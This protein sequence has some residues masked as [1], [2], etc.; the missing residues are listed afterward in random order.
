MSG[1]AQTAGGTAQRWLLTL[2]GGLGAALIAYGA[3][4]SHGNPHG[5]TP[6]P[7]LA[8]RLIPLELLVGLLVGWLVWRAFGRRLGTAPRTD[9]QE[10]MVYR[11]AMRRGGRFTL[12]ELEDGSPLAPAQAREVLERLQ[13]SGRLHRDGDTYHLNT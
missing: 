2:V 1:P 13:D 5:G 9:A 6:D 8:A 7:A 4:F 10:R 12:A 11:L 3:A